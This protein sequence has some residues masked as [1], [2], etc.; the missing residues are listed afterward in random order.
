LRCEISKKIDLTSNNGFMGNL[1]YGYLK[2]SLPS[3]IIN[4][5]LQSLRQHMNDRVITRKYSSKCP[6]FSTLA[7]QMGKLAGVL[8][9]QNVDVNNIN[10]ANCN[11]VTLDIKDLTD[12]NPNLTQ[13]SYQ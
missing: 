9:V 3:S 4:R 1:P 5:T 12:N 6:Q 11:R 10:N 7:T 8:G 2:N 13:E